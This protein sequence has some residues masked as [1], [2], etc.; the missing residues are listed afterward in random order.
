MDFDWQTIWLTRPS[1]R[2]LEG[3]LRLSQRNFYYANL[4][5]ALPG[6]ALIWTFVLA[7]TYYGHE[8]DLGVLVGCGV[9]IFA[10]LVIQ[11]TDLWRHHRLPPQEIISAGEIW[12]IWRSV[13]FV[14]SVYGLT[15]GLIYNPND[16]TAE[17]IAIL[18]G[19]GLVSAALSGMSCIPIAAVTYLL[20]IIV[21]LVLAM[22]LKT[23]TISQTLLGMVLI[24]GLVM[25]GYIRQGF[26]AFIRSVRL[27]AQNLAL[28]E[29]SQSANRAKT[30][31]LAAMSHEIRTPISGVLGM[32]D[33]ILQGELSTDQRDKAILARH[34]ATGLLGVVNDALDFS[35]LEQKS[36]ALHI[37]AFDLRDL[38][39]GIVDLMRV[40]AFQKNLTIDL[41]V[42]PDTPQRILSDPGRVRQILINL[43]ANAVKFTEAGSIKVSVTASRIEDAD[44]VLLNISV[45]DTGIGISPEIQGRLFHRFVQADQ[46]I[47]RRFGG[48]GLG[49]AISKEL[50]ELLGGDICV[51]S[52]LGQGTTFAVKVPVQLVTALAPAIPPDPVAVSPRR[53]LIAE[54]NEVNQYYLKAVLTRAGHHIELAVDG[55]AAIAMTR[56]KKFDAILMDIQ[57]PVLD[58]IGAARAIREPE[59]LNRQTPIIALTANIDPD[60]EAEVKQA[61]INLLIL[62]PIDLSQLNSALSSFALSDVSPA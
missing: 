7:V 49:L 15:L 16:V 37:E 6:Q 27:S 9:L 60:L 22:I 23:E 18:L 17:L 12:R 24:Y 10:G 39:Q 1:D 45:S 42:S 54:D 52:I 19:A 44:P 14:A 58:G 34:S 28:L 50:T 4:S 35:R 26:L 25:I 48:A 57:M 53:L 2:P 51:T 32:L 47:S 30:A 21:P 11:A 56:L 13:L 38:L 43:I 41:V 59:N 5:I 8:I 46:S 29:E 55:E 62:K 31:F 3:A 40:A 33:L 61:G 36:L 20:G